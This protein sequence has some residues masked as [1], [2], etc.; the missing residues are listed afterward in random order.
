MI[1]KILFH[2]Y[3]VAYTCHDVIGRSFV[4]Q[5]ITPSLLTTHYSKSS[6]FITIVLLKKRMT[7]KITFRTIPL[8]GMPPVFRLLDKISSTLCVF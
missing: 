6:S 1:E 5:G 3:G 2:T 4:G 8:F 7:I